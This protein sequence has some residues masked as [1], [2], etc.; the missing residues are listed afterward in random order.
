MI[1]VKD[2]IDMIFTDILM[3]T[4]I[5]IWAEGN[6]YYMRKELSSGEVTCIKSDNGMEVH[7]DI[8]E[9]P[10]HWVVYDYRYLGHDAIHEII[11][12]RY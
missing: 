3:S 7:C 8:K 9:I 5:R 6:Y 4:C 12:A 10:T 11:C 1:T 2:L